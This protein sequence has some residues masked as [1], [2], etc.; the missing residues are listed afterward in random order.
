MAH[1]LSTD[2]IPA[3]CQIGN[4][5]VYCTKMRREV[6]S[7]C[8]CQATQWFGVSLAFRPII[9]GAKGVNG[10]SGELDGIVHSPESLRCANAM[11]LSARVQAS[12]SLLVA[13][14]KERSGREIVVHPQKVCFSWT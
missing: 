1:S 13:A 3:S 4:A 11:R 9:L 8:P 10:A 12:S 5:V 2:P 7:P 14:S 6:N